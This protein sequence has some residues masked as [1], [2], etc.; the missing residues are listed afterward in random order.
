MAEWP[1]VH[2]HELAASEKS[3]FSKPYGSAI[4]KDDYL[5]QGVPVVRGVNLGKGIFLD[6]EFV[7]ISNEKA[8]Q[9]P[10]ANLAPGDLVITH[11]GTIGQVSM[12]PR[13]PRYSRYVLSTSQVKARLDLKRALPE[14]YYYWFASPTGRHELISKSSTVG[15]PGI[16]QPVAT[17]K[18]LKV[19]HPPL[20]VQK[21]IAHLL[22]AL[23]DKI[24]VNDRIARSSE[25]LVIAL[26]SE[27][28]WSSTTSLGSI[29]NHVRN[30][31]A[32]KELT[33]EFV[34]HYSLPAFDAG[35][36]PEIVNPNSIKSAKFLVTSPAVLLSKLNPTTPRVWNVA[37]DN[38]FP[39][40]ASTE[41]LVLRPTDY[42]NPAEVWAVCSQPTFTKEVAGKVTGTSNSH[43]RVKPGDLL[44]A[45]VTDPRSIPLSTRHQITSLSNR[46]QVSRQEAAVLAELRD[47]LLPKLM[48]GEIRVRDAEKTVEDA[49]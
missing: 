31:V 38:L 28:R 44:A 25:E 11:R 45:D 24:A 30:Q 34:A 39:A 5:P 21:A 37:P 2:F 40:L 9:M 27:E 15:V 47:T 19:P 42:L 17:I 13:S 20:S 32:P 36:R 16:G 43:Q 10:G 6:D 46:A 41:F 3:A 18:S 35:R 1:I 12:I 33:A 14:F 26:A 22:A 49:A 7:F 23:D 48:S 8:D 4:T 29:V